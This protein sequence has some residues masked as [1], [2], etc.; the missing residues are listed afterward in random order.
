[1]SLPETRGGFMVFSQSTYVEVNCKNSPGERIERVLINGEELDEEQDY[2]FSDMSFV[3]GGRDGFSPFEP[4]EFVERF[5]ESEIDIVLGF[6]SMANDLL[7][8]KEFMALKSSG[9]TRL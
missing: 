5:Q 1:M 8:E 9:I 6:C 3:M 4:D 2:L 7:Y